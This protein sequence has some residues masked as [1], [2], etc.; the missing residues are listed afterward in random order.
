MLRLAI[1]GEDLG[2]FT[3]ADVRLL[4]D[5]GYL[6]N[7]NPYFWREGMTEWRPILEAVPLLPLLQV[8]ANKLT[9][10]YNKQQ[11][12]F[13]EQRLKLL[14]KFPRFFAEEI[15]YAK[16]DLQEAIDARQERNEEREG[17]VQ[18]WVDKFSKESI[19]EL[20]SEDVE[21]Y[22]KTFKK[23]TKAQIT[24]MVVHCEQTLGKTLTYEAD[25]FFDLFAELFPEARKTKRASTAK[26]AAPTRGA[27]A[28]SK[29]KSGC[30]GWIVLALVGLL[31]LSMCKSANESNQPKPQ[32]APAPAT[33]P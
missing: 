30:L 31:A 7:A 27:R 25:D 17:D 24:K 1:N 13:A 15:E 3:E 9:D 2:E 28:N 14:K 8:V 4:F 5:A 16:E 12:S 6:G 10:E 21:P 18:W 29:K 20:S 22:L 33:S 11:I 19:E 26:R 32:G 23:P